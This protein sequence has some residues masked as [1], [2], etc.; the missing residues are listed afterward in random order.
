[1][2]TQPC[3]DVGMVH[4]MT[5]QSQKAT[6]AA[7]AIGHRRL[8]TA[9]RIAAA[10]SRPSQLQPGNRMPAAV[11]GWAQPTMPIGGTLSRTAMIT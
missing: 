4:E 7:I 6:T 8:T 2:P 10:V 11:I 9:R 1:M 5:D 3:R